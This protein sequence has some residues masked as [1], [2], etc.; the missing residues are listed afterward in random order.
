MRT[1][2]N[3]TNLS[4]IMM[5]QIDKASPMLLLFN[6]LQSDKIFFGGGCMERN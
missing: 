2:E 6:L 1:K 5:V 3:E 4:M